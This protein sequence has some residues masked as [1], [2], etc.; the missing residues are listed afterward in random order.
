MYGKPKA[1]PK[2]KPAPAPANPEDFWS[3]GLGPSQQR[4]FDSKARYL[5]VEG[6]RFSG[7]TYG[8]LH[9]IVRHCWEWENAHVLI[10][11]GVKRQGTVGGS[12]HKLMTD[13]LPTWKAN[14]DGFDHSDQKMTVEKDAVL[15]LTNKHGGWSM[16]QLISI[17]HGQTLASRVK[18]I[19]VS[20]IFVDELVGIG[21]PEYFEALIQQLGRRPGIPT[22]E[23]Q[24]IAATNPDG[25][26]HW[27]YKRWHELPLNAETGVWDSKYEWV[28]IPISENPSP[29]AKAYYENVLEATR[30]DPIEY[31]RMIEG[32][33][34]DRPSGQAIFV[35]VFVP[36]IHVRGDLKKGEILYPKVGLPITI[37]Y[38]LGDTNHA[39]VFLQERYTR[40][41]TFWVAFDELVFTDTKIS[42]DEIVPQLLD[43]M[44][45]WCVRSSYSFTFQH[46]SDKSA[47]NRFRSATGSYDHKQVQDLSRDLL[48]KEAERFTFLK[49]PV[50]MEECPKPPGSVAARVKLLRMLFQR[51]EM[52][53]S[54]RCERLTDAMNYLETEKDEPYSPKRS[55]HLHPYDALTYPLFYA[56]LGGHL[57]TT[58]TPDA[59][60]QLTQA[61]A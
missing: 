29:Q 7:K 56:S 27:V 42:I 48:K 11:V 5:L 38:D 14:L 59:T 26:S 52:F 20:M 8:I 33:W 47:F 35:N 32:K 4:V 16:V 58:T 49:K 34:V 45:E 31:A 57:M 51:E 6:E 44:Q 50:Y 46:I 19:E 1:A 54:A 12:W 60:P 9:K 21:G 30:N 13:V 40:E 39:M 17:P 2:K 10:V 22:E 61:G 15:W 43:L 53:I 41:K 23:Q 24:Y 36:E 3:P 28:H 25:P 18:G 37:G 55:K